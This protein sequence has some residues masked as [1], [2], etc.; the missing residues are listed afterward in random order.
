[1]QKGED[2]MAKEQLDYLGTIKEV[3]PVNFKVLYAFAAMPARY[4]LE[5]RLWD[6]AATMEISPPGFP[7]E[8]FA[9]QKAIIHFTRVLGL[10]H[11]GKTKEAEIELQNLK[12]LHA[13]LIKQKT[14]AREASQV[15][16][17]I[18]SAEA[19]LQYKAGNKTTALEAMTTAATME[20]ATEKHPVTPGEI[21]PARELLAD[22]L[23]EMGDYE[24]ALK[25]YKEV[26]R[27]HPNRFNG[28]Y[29]ATIAAQKSGNKNEAI[30]FA[31]NLVKVAPKTKRKELQIAKS[32]AG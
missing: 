11:L 12:G 18:K 29:G 6:K 30:I 24:S 3:Y 27:T 9:W 23:M 25:N 15:E 22:M 31:K 5:K 14:M 32:L 13:S 19:W 4:Y 10:V 28:L 2:E 1:L 20:D 17:Q 8:K 16:V 7:W 26:L 21:I